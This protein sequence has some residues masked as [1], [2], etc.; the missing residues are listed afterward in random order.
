MQCDYNEFL[1]GKVERAKPVGFDVAPDQ[2]HPMLFGWQRDVVRWACKQGRAALF[3][4]CGLGKT[5]QQVEWARLVSQHTNGGKVLILAPLAVAH[6]TVAEGRKIGID[7]RYVRSQAEVDA[8]GTPIVITNY[9]MLHHFDASQFSGVVLDESSILKAF[10]GATKRMLIEMF[11]HTAFR[12]A[13]TATPAPNDHLE[14]GNHAEFLGIMQSNRMISRWFINDTMAAGSYRLKKHAADDFW[15]WMVSWSVCIAKPSDLGDY[16][17]NGFVIPPLHIHSSV[18]EV[19]HTR[20]FADGQ[21]FVIES[22]SATGMWK[23][24]RETEEARCQM[25]KEIIGDSDDY[26]VIWCDTNSEADLLKALFPD[27]VEVR[28]SDSIAEKERK[29]MLFSD[30]AVKKIITKPEIAGFGLNWQH[31]ANM[32]FVGVTY[33]FEKTYQAMRRTWRFGQPNEVNAY[34]IYAETEGNI[35]ATLDAKQVKHEEMLRQMA[36]ASQEGGLDGIIK[37]H[38]PAIAV[39]TDI[40]QGENWTILLGD[41]IQTIDQIEDNSLDFSIFSPPFSTLYIYTDTPADMGNNEDHEQF[42]EHFRYLIDKLW[43]KVKPGRLVAVHCKDLPLYMNRDGAAGLYDF[44]GRLVAEFEKERYGGAYNRWTYHSRVTIWKDPVIEMQRTKNHGLLWKNHT[45]RGEVSR[46][47]M[48][49]YV[50]VF[51]KWVAPQDMPDKQVRNEPVPGTYIG[52]D[53]PHHWENERDYSIQVWQ[54]YASPVWFDIRQ[55]NVLN[56]RE[57]R[58]K[59][60]EKHIC[61]LQLDV[62]ERCIELWTNPGDLVH[63]P[64]AGIGSEGYVSVKMGRRFI[65]QELKRSYFDSAVGYLRE[66]ESEMAMPDLFS[67]AAQ[68]AE[69][70]EL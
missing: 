36:Q 32:A 47:G 58:D 56:V 30:G 25:A 11:S 31:C 34:M 4:E 12:L 22:L 66:L 14:F 52:E 8:A 28:G 68:E 9:D 21:L 23:E 18:V 69:M 42:F 64:F 70:S 35:V 19:D 48:P 5:L 3:E 51:R 40:A 2:V 33:S 65:G 49:D 24:K 10:T 63:S 54:K 38:A 17:D 43:H 29:L 57:A 60:D 16:D 59:E 15:R 50:L 44:P 20:A 6:Q 27:A 13:C 37:R 1:K 67:W 45:V 41:S 26:W 53:A 39:E 7:V 46:Q 62:I 61:P 55:T